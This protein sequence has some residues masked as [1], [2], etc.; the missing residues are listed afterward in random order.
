MNI[1]RSLLRLMGRRLPVT[2]GS[3]EVE[4]LAGPV[5]IRRDRFGVPHI[6]ATTPDDAWFGLGFCQGQDRAFQIET[7]IRVVRGTLAALVGGDAFAVD[8]L[9]RRV[10][11]ARYGEAVL[12]G[13]RRHHRSGYEAFAA[14]VRAGV[15][16]GGGGRVHEFTL[17]RTA[18]TPFAA[19]DAVGFLAVQAFALASNWDTELARLRMLALD[20][21]EAVAALHP[22]YPADLPVSDR[23]GAAAGRVVDALADDLARAR[24][25]FTPGGGSNNWAIAGSRTKTG[26]PI[27]ANDPHLAPVLPPHWYLAHLA[28]PHWTV[29]GA[30]LPAVPTFAAGHNQHAAWGVTA[31]LID[32][33]DLFIEEVGPDNASVRRG[34]EFVPCEVRREVIEV[35]GSE[36]VTID[37]L[38]TDRGP[39]VGPAFEGP[40]GAL[41]MSATWL[42]PDD[43]GATIDLCQ[44]GS[45][46]DLRRVYGPWTSVPLNVAFADESGTIGWQLIGSA[47]VRGK[48]GGTIPLEASD[49]ATRWE[50]D[51]VPFEELPHAVDPPSGFVATANNLPSADGPY[52][53]SDFLDGY[54]VQRISELLAERD[55]W[56]VAATLRLQLDQHSIPWREMRGVVLGA[57]EDV[58]GDIVAALRD[59]DGTVG[60]DS[61]GATVFEVLVAEM[62]RRVAEAKAPASA[63][64]ALGGGFTPLVPFSGLLVR[65][66]SHLVA[67]LREQPDGWFA[68]GW[69]P[70][71]RDALVTTGKILTDRYGPD[72]GDWAWGQV[73]PLRLKHPLGAR[74]ALQGL[75]DLGPF[76][77]GGD[78]NTVNP[79]PVDPRDPLR[80]PDFAIASLRMVIDV[81]EW[82]NARFSLP[83]GQSGNPF[84]PHYAD[85]LPLWRRGDGLTIAQEPSEVARVARSTLAL[86]PLAESPQQPREI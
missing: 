55:D 1:T 11:F 86:A 43:I 15:G 72:I 18:P 83:G 10:G 76:P 62:C 65:R 25:L 22:P 48:G 38:E 80:N 56:D 3:L 7:R 4:G 57:T 36:P 17:L 37:V 85:Q 8:E 68:T 29:T 42:R 33:T 81:G 39:V 26:R 35:R 74:R 20:G 44:V 73:R 13:M 78:A 84:S 21:P 34:G 31:G 6:E 67:L 47:P 41:S 5:T 45:F 9:S 32:N 40:F 53:G 71:I 58:G 69:G 64:L 49:P 50:D 75:Y 16:A 61:P 82:E 70:M 23:P 19:A 52:L 24:E 28:T 60:P 2:S 77:H 14:G 79:A 63:G 27:L 66:V 30:S 12:A 51:P 59:W 54:R 46:A